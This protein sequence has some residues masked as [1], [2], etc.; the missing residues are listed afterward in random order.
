M[1][2]AVAV[3][4]AATAAVAVAAAVAAAAT[5]AVVVAVGAIEPAPLP[6]EE[7]PRAPH[8]GSGINFSLI[9]SPRPATLVVPHYHPEQQRCHS[10]RATAM[11]LS[12][13]T[14]GNAARSAINPSIRLPASIRN[15][16][17]S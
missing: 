6:T 2:A 9:V 14:S 16:P 5:A 15:A 11:D 12:W 8:R 3:D 13:I 1:A 7:N 17:S 4:A 10:I